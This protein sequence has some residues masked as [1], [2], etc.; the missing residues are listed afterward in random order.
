MDA[1]TDKFRGAQVLGMLMLSCHNFYL[2]ILCINPF[3]MCWADGPGRLPGTV[4]VC[5]AYH[6]EGVEYK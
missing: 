4:E 2:P 5:E 6:M 3:P 1:A